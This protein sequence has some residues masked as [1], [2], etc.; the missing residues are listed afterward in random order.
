M[1][2]FP[3]PG[4]RPFRRDETDIFFGREEH[5]TRLI[6][7]LRETRFLAVTG[8]SGC[9]KSSLVRTG[10]IPALERG[11]LRK[12]G[13]SWKIAE[14]RPSNK[15]LLNLATA[16]S[17]ALTNGDKKHEKSTLPDQ[18]PIESRAAI[19]RHSPLGVKEMLDASPM[20]HGSHL[21]IL[22]DQFE[23]IF[24]YVQQGG[25]DEADAFVDLLLES[26]RQTSHSIYVVITLRSDFLG[27]CSHF[28]QLPAAITEG[29]F[30]T[31][32]L[33]RNQIRSAIE[34]PAR[35]FGGK[36]DPILVN[37]LLND[38]G[39][40]HDQLPLLQHCLMRMWHLAK[41][42]QT[43]NSGVCLTL[44]YYWGEKIRSLGE[45]LSIHADEVYG[46]LA[47]ED[48]K[49]VAERLFRCLTEREKKYQRDTQR[50][51]ELQKVVA[52]LDVPMERVIEVVEAFRHPA[53]GF[54]TPTPGVA[55]REDTLL[56]ISHESLIRQWKRLG[57]WVAAE[58]EASEKY[59]HIEKTACNW[60]RGEAQLWHSPELDTN[61]R[62]WDKEEMPTPGWAS[63]YGEKFE[64]A[65]EFL[66]ESIKAQRKK[67]VDVELQHQ[68]KVLQVKQSEELKRIRKQRVITITGTVIAV[69]LAIWGI[70]G[71]VK[72]NKANKTILREKQ[73]VEDAYKIA[74]AKTIEA[75]KALKKVKAQAVQLRKQKKI[76][77]DKSKEALKQ[78]EI[79]EELKRIADIK[80]EEAENQRVNALHNLGLVFKEKVVSAL[81]DNDVNAVRAYSLMSLS[82]F[83]QKGGDADKAA[84]RTNV[85][86]YPAH[87]IILS[88]PGAQ[89]HI[90]VVSSVAFS[91]DGK[92][93]AS[94]SFDCTIK[95]WDR[96]S[97]REIS[98]LNG[99]DKWVS[100]VAFSPDGKTVASSSGDRTVKLWNSETGR[101][102]YSLNG[103]TDAV[104]SVAVSP[105]GKTVASGSGDRT[106]KLWDRE[107]GREICSLKG[108]TNAV[109]CVTFSPD[110][111]TVASGSDDK[112]I[113]L[114]NRKTTREIS[115]LKG[116]DKWVSGIAFSPDGKT[117]ASS[118]GDNTIKLWDRESGREIYSLKG[119]ASSVYSVAFSPDSLTIASGS[120]DNTI[121]L[122]D[123]ETGREISTLRG[124]E[125]WVSGVAF[126]PDGKTVASGS[127][128]NTIKLWDRKTGMAFY[129]LKGHADAVRS[130]AFS[131]DGTTVASGSFDSTI[132]LWDR[133]SGKELSTL[134]G[135]AD[136]VSSV[137][138]SPDGLTVASGSYD[139]AI[140]LWDRATSREIFTLKGHTYAVY[141]VAF[142]PDG[143]AV[144][145]G[146]GD[147]TIKLWG[148]ETGREIFTLKGHAAAI[149]S[150]AFSPDGK[151][152]AS[153]SGDNTIKLWDR[154]TGKEIHTLKGHAAAISSIA[155]SLDGKTVAS[156]SHDDTIKL[157]DKETGR[158]IS[159]LN[160]HAAAVYSVA[161]SPDGKAVASGSD[162]NSIKLWD[163]E[164]GMEIYSLKGHADT[165]SSVA[166]S[167][168]GKTV[169]SG[170]G[171]NSIK[172]W[173]RETGREICSLKGHADTVS[174]VAF[175][176]DGKAVASGSGEN[177]IKLWERETSK[178]ICSLK[179]HASSVYSVAFSPDGK[180]VASGSNDNTIKL[181]DRESG[182]EI[183]TLRGHDKWVSGVTFSP[184]GKTVASGSG[185][186]TI[187]LWDIAFM[188][189]PVPPREDVLKAIE[190]DYNLT[191]K[192]IELIPINQTV[193]LHGNYLPPRWPTTH[194][195]H[196]IKM[197]E[198]G[199]SD[200]MVQ[201]G[202]IYDRDR[203]DE[204]ATY[205]YTK[206]AEA[207]N[208]YG[209]ER[210]ALL[211]KL[212]GKKPAGK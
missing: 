51:I 146:S 55:L 4:L 126:S 195:I 9:G 10:M 140:K 114:W 49:K 41:N 188:A 206:A 194:P 164:S 29:Q 208:E 98:T 61:L 168:D 165:V 83:K 110:G 132:K 193:D 53:R 2:D 43:D 3:Y 107:T 52:A 170:S 118:S 150:V 24:R 161:F 167:P 158:E 42:A 60:K 16:I 67:D 103:H 74:D 174:S 77:E 116:H 210:L 6:D 5:T 159:T 123:R 175:S 106:I 58:A 12:A 202:I 93:I 156:G 97:G 80:T 151:T 28:R 122:W 48:R 17:S 153:G 124:H 69:F 131:P 144:A 149:S 190:R 154:E 196:W 18:K 112:T 23:E 137:A 79:A 203:K 200:A 157:W 82:H 38:M 20:P 66:D 26:S 143:K 25:M 197:A 172:L 73:T 120:D 95:L 119:H 45:S 129:P 19:L 68:E 11:L 78:K 65:R 85:A 91:P 125:K 138:F 178:E 88:I 212:T 191:L 15:P 64:L 47:D 199:D 133:E 139:K 162:D 22:V 36:I 104:R 201:L 130:V 96:E 189:K 148:R 75:E 198:R 152:F 109:S 35:V 21:L 37:R 99:H 182:R 205:W 1:S 81:K 39:M 181:W 72:S 177:S 13:N 166:F 169:A 59:I 128:D 163:I 46:N 105:D 50:P 33:T 171:D 94:G 179:G 160:G 111:L 84:V 204:K 186:S 102:I 209:K 187:K 173:E 8:D 147:G 87:P 142:S 30:P 185:D 207:G 115:T 90:G 211:R 155:F 134:K 56:D 135:H 108:H 31:P 76:A 184:D 89:H 183:C 117:V 100:G 32:R 113:K 34:G 14:M 180:T 92:T 7:K 71:Q 62:W 101:E 121:K 70:W 40:D 127:G 57:A 27:D 44:E 54:L 145:S 192:G 141:S 136:A 63:R 176:P 86:S